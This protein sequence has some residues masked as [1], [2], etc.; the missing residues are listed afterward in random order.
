MATVAQLIKH[1]QQFPQETQVAY[2]LYSE[3]CLL[4]L[5]DI[6]LEQLCHARPDGWIQNNR[7]DMPTLA[8]VL[9]PGH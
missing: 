5:A 2:P 8:Y 3:Y 9:F 1:L 4:D 7:P 6:R